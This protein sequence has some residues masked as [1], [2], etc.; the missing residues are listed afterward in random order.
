M[1]VLI[2]D[3]GARGHSGAV[4]YAR[5]DEFMEVI[6]APGN[7]GA[8]LDPTDIFHNANYNISGDPTVNLKDLASIVES[9]ERHKP[10]LVDVMQDDAVAVGTVDAL[11]ELG[12]NVVGPTKAA[13][14]IEWSKTWAR[15]RMV[16]YGMPVPEHESFSYDDSRGRDYAKSLAARD[17]IVWIKADG[18]AAGKGAVPANVDNVDIVWNEMKK[19]GKAAEEIVVEE[20]MGGEEFSWYIIADANGNYQTFRSAMDFKRRFA[21]DVGPN[22]GGMGSVSPTYIT[23]GI[24]EQID[25]EI[26]QPFIHGMI[27]DG[28]PYEGVAYFGGMKLSDGSV[29]LVEINARWGDPEAQVILPG[30]ENYLEL[31]QASVSGTLDKVQVDNDVWTRV[32]VVAASMTYPERSLKDR[33]VFIDRVR[34]STNNSVDFFSAG[35]RVEEGELYTNGGRLFSVVG[36]GRNPI[37]ARNDALNVLSNCHIE[38]NGLGY[39]HD[40]AHQD[41]AHFLETRGR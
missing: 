16:E 25:R 3:A 23:E 20:H 32:N 39:R 31:A 38:G 5:K 7:E 4:A 14:K 27:Q 34:R 33:R 30:V 17:G 9:V 29:K 15:E 12:Y 18:L 26:V 19:F 37:D 6:L 13:G 40:I 8:V 22:T 35:L 41:V 10:D 1:K 28:H 2:T 21:G 11:R 36:K 24:E